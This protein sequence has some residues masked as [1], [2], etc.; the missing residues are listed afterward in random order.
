TL[1]G[2]RARTKTALER[3]IGEAGNY[4]KPVTIG[5]ERHGAR[6]S[7]PLD[8]LPT[9]RHTGT[10]QRGKKKQDII[11]QDTTKKILTTIRLLQVG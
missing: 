6:S 8:T 3:T 2:W 7:E 10:R 4:G 11:N 1:V 9:K 5:T